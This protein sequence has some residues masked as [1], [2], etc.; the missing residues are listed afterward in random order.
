MFKNSF[1]SANNDNMKREQKKKHKPI[2]CLMW[3]PQPKCTMCDHNKNVLTAKTYN[4]K[5][6]VWWWECGKVNGDGGIF[7]E[8]QI[9]KYRA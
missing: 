7:D 2:M 4:R 1:F 3:I 6:K 5:V 9:M 8:K